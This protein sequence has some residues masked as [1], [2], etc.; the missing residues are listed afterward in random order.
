MTSNPFFLAYFGKPHSGKTHDLMQFVKTCG[1]H[2]IFVYNSGHD[3]DW[4]GFIEIELISDPKTKELFFVYKG[5]KYLFEKWFMK[6]FKGKKVKAMM[7]DEKLTEQLLYKR[8]SRKGYDGLFFII[9]DATNVFSSQLTQAQK[10]CF[11]RAKHV[12]IWFALVFHD[13]NMFPNGA[14]GAL[15]L[16]RFFKNNVAPPTK[17]KDI[18]PHFDEVM[19][20]FKFLRDAPLYS[21]ATIVM[22]TGALK[23]KKA[24][25]A[26]K[27]KKKNVTNISKGELAPKVSTKRALKPKKKNV[28]ITKRQVK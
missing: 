7:A 24:K 23:K 25:R 14:W 6:K 11:Y 2:T 15:T 4:K 8:L 27:P 1:R 18:I 13:P 9:D 3:K 12:G 16:A 26:L 17:K 22:D 20:S 28:N 5:K 19:E 10:A 21:H